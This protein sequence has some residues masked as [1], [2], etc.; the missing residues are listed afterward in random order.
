MSCQLKELEELLRLFDKDGDGKISAKELRSC[1]EIAGEQLAE[2][3]AEA[4]IRGL[5]S[6]GDGLLAVEELA[7]RL[8]PAGEE[9]EEEL[10]E[11]FRVYESD[12]EGCITAGSLKR[13]LS[14]LGVKREMNQCRAMICRFDA[15]GDGVICF[16]EF[17]M[18]MMM[19]VP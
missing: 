10:R 8:E 2:E 7:A 3:D 17:K 1:V 12:D 13:T 5:D 14:R 9:E 15:N 16:E 6:D 11:A 19:T 18:M 4:L